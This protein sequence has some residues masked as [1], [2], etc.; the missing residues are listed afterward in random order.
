MMVAVILYAMC[1]GARSSRKIAAVCV[2]DV[3]GRFLSGGVTP[4]YKSF[5]EFQLTHKAALE[6]LLAQTVSLCQRA[7]L[8]DVSKTF[9]DGTKIKANAS[10]EQNVRYGKA[11][12]KL[13]Q[14]DRRIA[15]LFAQIERQDALDD[16]EHGQDD[17]S[18]GSG[19]DPGREREVMLARRERL[20]EAK[21]QLEEEAKAQ[22]EDHK[23]KCWQERR[24]VTPTGIPDKDKRANMTDPDSRLMRGCNEWLQGFNAQI[25][26]EANNHVIIGAVLNNEATDYNQL[27]AAIRSV[28]ETTG[29]A[30]VK[31]IADA[32]YFSKAN[33]KEAEKLGVPVL[34]PPG[35]ARDAQSFEA[36]EPL[37]QGE[38]D[39]L[40][41][42]DKMKAILST[43]QGH[44]DYTKRKSA[45]ETAFAMI[46]GCP[47]HPGI[48][49]FVRRGLEKCRADWMLACT[50][51]NLKRYI[52]A[53]LNE[54]PKSTPVVR[55]NRA[56][57]VQ[58][59]LDIA[60]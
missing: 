42:A 47:G 33:I 55:A 58:I 21:R 4:S 54:S 34:I 15:D 12:A 43:Q 27:G 18:P 30:P 48:R 59:V 41:P 56:K 60:G 2:D 11:D 53:K 26:V 17:D 6:R 37:P 1:K 38:L 16:D 8:V 46:K 39:R 31:L 5:Q 57:T 19:S 10:L 9:L 44:D 50:V 3:G 7:N 36:Q 25:V 40:D 32:G 22:F 28:K 29:V 24:H 23:S 14:I 49:Q 35:R 20:R 52:A 45:V 13:E 51:H